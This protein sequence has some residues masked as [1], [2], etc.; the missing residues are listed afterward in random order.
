MGVWAYGSHSSDDAGD[1]GGGD[2]FLSVPVDTV[3]RAGGVL[4]LLLL[5]LRGR[6]DVDFDLK[7]R[8]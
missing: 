3:P 6:G 1:L 7:T 8:I 4:L 2:G 5:L